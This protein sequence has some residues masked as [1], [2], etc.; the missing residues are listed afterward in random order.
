MPTLP[1]QAN[2]V[3]LS[4]SDAAAHP[5]LDA[6][7]PAPD[8]R[9]RAVVLVGSSLS[10]GDV[11][12]SPIGQVTVVGP[13]RGRDWVVCGWREYDDE[14]AIDKRAYGTFHRTQIA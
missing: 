7:L 5:A 4:A 8:R 11:V 12:T 13:G 10:V 1:P 2:D 3:A 14:L 6:S 9:N